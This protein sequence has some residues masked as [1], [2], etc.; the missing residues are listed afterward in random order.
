MRYGMWDLSRGENKIQDAGWSAVKFNLG[1][2]G[3]KDS[4][5]FSFFDYDFIKGIFSHNVE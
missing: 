3:G 1:Q 5:V 4:C 2:L